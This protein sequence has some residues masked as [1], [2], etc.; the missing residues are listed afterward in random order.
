MHRRH[1]LKSFALAASTAM[2]VGLAATG[3]WAANETSSR[4]ASSA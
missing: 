1:L 4:S 2:A 3:A